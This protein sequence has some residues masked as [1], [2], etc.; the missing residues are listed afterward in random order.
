MSLHRPKTQPVVIASGSH[1]YFYFDTVADAPYVSC[2]VYRDSGVTDNSGSDPASFRFEVTNHSADAQRG[3]Y[4]TPRTTASVDSDG[5]H[6]YWTWLPSATGSAE[7]NG[8]GPHPF[9]TGSAPAS[10]IFLIGNAGFR[11]WRLRMRAGS[12]FTGSIAWNAKTGG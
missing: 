5:G 1:Q 4:L 6:G 8:G 2:Q 7:L 11:H 3:G 12:N 9:F 10:K